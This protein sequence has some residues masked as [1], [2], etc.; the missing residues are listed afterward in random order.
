M[1]SLG[2]RVMPPLHV[3][4]V[5]PVGIIQ[6]CYTRRYRLDDSLLGNYSLKGWRSCILSRSHLF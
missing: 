5:H 3:T 1:S 4:E 6:L 2:A